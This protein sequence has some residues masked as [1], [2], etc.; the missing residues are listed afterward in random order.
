MRKSRE[1]ET[2]PTLICDLVLQAALH[3]G[4]GTA[5][6]ESGVGFTWLQLRSQVG[7]VAQGLLR[8]GVQPGE[9][10]AL[11]GKNSTH[12]LTYMFA[13]PAVGALVVPLNTRSSIEELA[14]VLDDSGAT[15]LVADASVE[16]RAIRAASSARLRTLVR[17]PAAP[18][19][20]RDR[21][22]S[23]QQDCSD[24]GSLTIVDHVGLACGASLAVEEWGCGAGDAY[25]I[26]YTS[27]TTGGAKGAVLSHRN[28]LFQASVKVGTVGISRDSIY[29]AALPLFHVGGVS[30][31]L[32]ATMGAARLVIEP[33]LQW[34]SAWR[35]IRHASID[36]LTVVPAVLQLLF[37]AIDANADADAAASAAAPA[38]RCVL[39]GGQ[40]RDE[41]GLN[42]RHRRPASLR[43]GIGCPLCGLAFDPAR[44][45]RSARIR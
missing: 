17:L 7:Q 44:G 10:V 19:E 13:I 20:L 12:L 31:A 6:I 11:L 21:S 23:A 2:F 8:V 28:Q 24:K 30:I 37:D 18:S 42:S 39:V 3:H 5:V 43:R 25:G 41:W 29:L 32:A 22:P 38:V 1:M 16:A 35:L 9:C 26:F 36:L 27:G 33:Q 45:S 34:G 14:H 15:L 40:V 4:D